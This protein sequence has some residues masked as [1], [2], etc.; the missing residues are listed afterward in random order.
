MHNI[1]LVKISNAVKRL[2]AESDRNEAFFTMITQHEAKLQS[3]SSE[4]QKLQNISTS[5]V[6][7]ELT[8][9]VNE[10]KTRSIGGEANTTDPE[11]VNK[12]QTQVQNLKDEL[13]K[14]IN[15]IPVLTYDE[16]QT[17][18]DEM[19][20]ITREDTSPEFK[21]LVVNDESKYA[22]RGILDDIIEISMGNTKLS[23][24]TDENEREICSITN[25]V[26]GLAFRKDGSDDI[27]MLDRNK[28]AEMEFHFNSMDNI[29]LSINP[30]GVKVSKMS[31]NGKTISGV[32]SSI[33]NDTI[34]DNTI[35]TV[36]AIVKYI[37]A[38]LQR[39][40]LLN[41]LTDG[42]YSVNLNGVGE[43]SGEGSTSTTTSTA[44]EGST[45]TT[46]STATEGSTSTVT[47]TPNT[48]TTPSQ[49]PHCNISMVK[50]AQGNSLLIENETNSFSLKD[51]EFNVV[52]VSASATDGLRVSDK[53]KLKNNI[54]TLCKFV[55]DGVDAV[56]GRF[57]EL[58][59]KAVKIDDLIVP[60]VKLTNKLTSM[61]YGLIKQ[62][63]K[64]EYVT[65]N[66][67]YK[68]DSESEYVSVIKSGF[69]EIPVN[70][71][72]FDLGTLLTA[73][74]NGIPTFSK[75]NVDAVKF[76]IDKKLPMV[77]IISIIDKQLIVEVV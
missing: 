58:T 49:L 64:N 8:D 54:G 12:L 31:L 17:E 4:I 36:G 50:T 3:I 70:E 68:L 63:P 65:Q 74:R 1:S 51:D 41:K 59:G 27:W 60:E 21:N 48:S 11:L 38:N 66:T 52:T 18:K 16:H 76:C 10:L 71:G 72:S 22:N 30:R 61:V 69:L 19:H 37:N 5:D 62:I 56:V 24:N 13:I 32:A 34:N 25:E 46:T 75:N 39:M 57:V 29:P 73:G 2:E 43:T 20:T 42:K 47:S 44:T 26:G 6:I 53:F 7:T 45:S 55:N 15:E 40:N 23:I 77:K 9:T 28:D 67:I 14:T 33:N 35:P